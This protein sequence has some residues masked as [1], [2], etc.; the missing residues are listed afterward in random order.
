MRNF[1]KAALAGATAVAVAF[2]S[3]AVATAAPANDGQDVNETE[4]T[5]V[6]EAM[7]TQ[8]QKAQEKADKAS[9]ALTAANTNVTDAQNAVNNAQESYDKA[10]A[11]GAP[12][13][14]IAAKKATLDNAKAK[15]RAA[16]D[17]Q[18]K[19][20]TANDKA[21]QDLADA[22][23]DAQKAA[24]E[25]AKA[26]AES[27]SGLKRVGGEGTINSDKPGKDVVVKNNDGKPTNDNWLVGYD[28]FGKTKDWDNVPNWA[29]GLYAGTWFTVAAAIV[30]L[31]VGPVYN[32]IVHGPVNF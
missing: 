7:K 27:R 28:M 23:T 2:G 32:F 30:G 5:R 1:R 12:S 14:E 22:K 17:A 13:A 18:A 20:K 31:I 19:A 4:A 10:V 16:E 26:K 11:Q 15:L 21:Q 6:S 29:K 3:T 8:A 24:D 25:E 9:D